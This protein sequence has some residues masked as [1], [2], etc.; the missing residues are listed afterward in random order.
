MAEKAEQIRQAL[1]RMAG[2]LGPDN[3]LLAQVKSVNSEDLTCDL[4]DDDSGLDYVDVR[5]RPVIDANESITLFPKI[6]SWVLAIRIEDSE[7]WMVLA[8][9]EIDKWRLSIGTTVIEQDSIGLLIQ[10]GD[11]TLKEIIQLIIEAMQQIVVLQGTNPDYLKLTEAM[12]KLN[13][14]LR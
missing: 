9:G 3:S 2:E 13:N 7:D 5:L 11:D 1:K 6:D 12:D 10:K 4:Y 14:V 8:A